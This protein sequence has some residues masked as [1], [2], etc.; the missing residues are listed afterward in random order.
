MPTPQATDLPAVQ[1]D[2]VFDLDDT[3][4]RYGKKGA[5]VP[6]QTFHCLR[7]LQLSGKFKIS[8]VSYNPFCHYVAASVGLLKFA[9]KIQYGTGWRSDLVA[10]VVPSTNHRFL[11][12]DDR[13]DSLD[14]VAEAFPHAVCIHV[15]D[16][17]ILHKLV[18]DALSEHRVLL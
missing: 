17:L 5:C 14:A 6:R 2:I 11:Y 1:K 9:D 16:P 18:A 4:V 13:R 15:S 3:L 7:D 12:F 8:I 10:E